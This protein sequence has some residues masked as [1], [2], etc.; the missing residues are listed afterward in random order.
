MGEEL[1]GEGNMNV[2]DETFV[3]FKCVRIRPIMTLNWQSQ[4]IIF[5][6]DTKSVSVD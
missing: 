3:M 4:A 5:N 6:K 1:N 2:S